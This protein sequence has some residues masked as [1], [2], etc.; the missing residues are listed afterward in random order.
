MPHFL[1]S[2]DDGEIFFDVDVAFL[3]VCPEETALYSDRSVTFEN[4]VFLHSSERF[5]EQMRRSQ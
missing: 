1:N 5:I 4:I 2:A 3:I